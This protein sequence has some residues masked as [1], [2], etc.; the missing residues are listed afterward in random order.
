MKSNMSVSKSAFSNVPFYSR[1]LQDGII[2]WYQYEAQVHANQA[3]L[4]GKGSLCAQP[5]DV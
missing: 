1:Y 2:A 3:A 5:R 4:E